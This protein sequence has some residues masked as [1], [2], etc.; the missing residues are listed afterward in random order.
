MRDTALRAHDVQFMI[1]R[2]SS[3]PNLFRCGI[4]A[5]LPIAALFSAPA[6]AQDTVP[7]ATGQDNSDIAAKFGGDNLTIG[8]AGAY[9]P[10]YEGSNDYRFVPAPLVIGQFKGFSFT[11]IGNRASLDLIPNHPADKIDFQ[12]GPV[13]VLSFDRTKLKDIDDRAVRRLGK[14]NTAI[15]VGG[16]I[17]IGKTGVITSPYDKISAS[18]SYRHDVNNAHDSGIWQPAISYLTPLSRKAAVGFTASANHVGR[19]Y[20]QTYFSISPQQS[21]SSGLPVYTARAG[22]KNYQIGGY[23]TYALTGDLLHGFKL[24]VGGAY[25]RLLGSYSYSPIVRL[26]G[27]PNQWLGAA[28]V[29]YTF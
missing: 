22:W 14:I 4:A 19:G 23:A 25:S 9:V 5:V 3:V 29:A 10:D 28:G 11:V 7:A 2:E 12:F 20:A 27:K 15:E 21:L 26:E 18:V 13:A 16:F 17:G 6:F 8:G 1:Y 24:I